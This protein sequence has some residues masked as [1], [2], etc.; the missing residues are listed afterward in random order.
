MAGKHPKGWV[1][2]W[3]EDQRPVLMLPL[4]AVAS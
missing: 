4:R 2:V 3:D 1:E